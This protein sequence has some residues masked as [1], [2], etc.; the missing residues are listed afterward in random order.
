M[1]PYVLIYAAAFSSKHCFRDSA[2]FCI[3]SL[4]L[5]IDGWYSIV[6]IYQ[7]VSPVSYWWTFKWSPVLTVMNKAAI[8]ICIQFFLWTHIHVTLEYVGW[9]FW[10]IGIFNCLTDHLKT[11]QTRIISPSFCRSGTQEQLTWGKA[12]ERPLNLGAVF[13]LPGNPRVPQM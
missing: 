8:N 7:F 12:L 5:L 10:L 2:T 9:K 3:Y 13:L 11:V 4:S 1:K 6:C